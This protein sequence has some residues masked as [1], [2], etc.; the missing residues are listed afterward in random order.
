[1]VDFDILDATKNMRQ[2]K[3]LFAHR[4]QVERDHQLLAAKKHEMQKRRRR[5]AYGLLDLLGD[6]KA[7]L[8]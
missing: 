3:F 2:K 4:K 5:S 6:E 7:E 8:P 1:L